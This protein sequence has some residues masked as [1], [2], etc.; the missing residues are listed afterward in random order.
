[1]KCKCKAKPKPDVT[2]FRGTTAV[3]ESAKIKI[4]VVDKEEDVY[5]LSLEIKVHSKILLQ[6]NKQKLLAYLCVTHD[7]IPKFSS[8]MCISKISM[9][10]KSDWQNQKRWKIKMTN[11]EQ[12][13]ANIK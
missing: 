5:E 10:Q 12:K 11:Y 4:H 7:K 2:W 13:E 8:Q 9:N 6:T 1:M 3:K